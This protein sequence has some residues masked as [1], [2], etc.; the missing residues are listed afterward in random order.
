MT[1]SQDCLLVE[2]RLPAC[3]YLGTPVYMTF[4]ICDLDLGL[5][6]LIYKIYIKILK[7]CQFLVQGFQKLEH[8]QTD[9][10]E[11]IA[12]DIRRC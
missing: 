8:R 4:C 5:M 10:A 12:S 11:Q 6:T 3:L 1:D 7:V 2:G 9:A